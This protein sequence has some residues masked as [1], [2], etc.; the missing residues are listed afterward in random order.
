MIILAIE[1]SCDETAVAIV[2]FSKNKAEVLANIVSSQVKAHSK[3]GGVVPSL[4]SRM[5]LKN[6]VPVLTRALKSAEKK[7]DHSK[8]GV[9][10]LE[11]KNFNL[12][13]TNFYRL[14]PELQNYI[15]YIAVTNGPGLIPALMI[16]V[17]AA[18]SLSY[19]LDKPLI[20]IHHIEGHIYANWLTPKK[21]QAGKLWKPEFPIICLTVSG[22]HT[23]IILMKK[24]L[25]YKII[26]ETMDDAA[27]EAFDKVA[28]LLGFGYPGG[29][30]IEKMAKKG[31]RN[32]FKFTRPMINSKNY[33]FS[34]SGLKTAVLY[35]VRSK[36]NFPPDKGGWGVGSVEVSLDNQYKSDIAASFQQAVIDVL[37]SKTIKAAKQYK[38]KNIILGGGVSA[39]KELQKQFMEEIPLAPFD[40]G[41][42][43]FPK[44]RIL[45][46]NLS[47]DNAL[48]VAVAAYC[49]IKNNKG[50]G[51]WKSVKA[52]ANLKLK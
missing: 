16:G 40:K 19:T 35:E 45:N 13:E 34:F 44:F 3:F 51:N 17:N 29:P 33:N 30:L 36:Q 32:K 24:D 28:K 8:S 25:N 38:A 12:N 2:K 46:T 9:H 4:A 52:D 50:I 48:M 47:T 26:G 39:N 43:T 15:D 14:K 42:V 11:C 6:M 22:G 7:L 5:H 37:I 21:L 49:R 18:R 27:G 20:G 31:D 1:T 23:Q 10:S 41:G